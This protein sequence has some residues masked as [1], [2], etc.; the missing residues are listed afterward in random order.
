VARR[1][2]KSESSNY[3]VISVIGVVVV[4]AVVGGVFITAAEVPFAP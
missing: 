2:P 1:A 3:L 4:L